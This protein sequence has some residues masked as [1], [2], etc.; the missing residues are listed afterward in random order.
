MLKQRLLFTVVLVVA[1][2]TFFAFDWYRQQ[3]ASIFYSNALRDARTSENVSVENREY[4]VVNGIVTPDDKNSPNA[5]KL[6]Y[7]KTMARRSPFFALPEI[8]LDDFEYAV[9][10]LE[11]TQEKLANLQKTRREKIL[12]GS[13]LYPTQFLKALS[14]TERARRQFLDSGSESDMWSYQAKEKKTL[15][16]YRQSLKRFRD[17]FDA[18]IPVGSRRYAMADVITDR[19]SILDSI[20]KLLGKAD[21]ISSLINDRLQCLKGNSTTCKNTDLRLPILKLEDSGAISNTSLDLSEDVRRILYAA[22]GNHKML[23]GPLVALSESS[24]LPGYVGG[25][26]FIFQTGDPKDG[27]DHFNLPRFVGDIRF[28]KSGEQPDPFSRYFRANGVEFLISNPFVY[29]KCLQSRTDHSK[30]FATRAI[31]EFASQSPIS[32]YMK[33]PDGNQLRVLEQLLFPTNKVIR[34]SD[35]VRYLSIAGTLSTAGKLPKD[36]S[37]KIASL[38]LAA[39]TPTNGFAEEIRRISVF[40]NLNMKLTSIGLNLDFSATRLFLTQ[41]AFFPLFLANNILNKDEISV[42]FQSNT[43]PA[44]KQPYIFYSSLPKTQM[45]RNE[46]IHDIGFYAQLH[47]HM[48]GI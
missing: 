17:A 32:E 12:V 21:K 20:D 22:T 8:N 6:A 2:G 43:I 47:P 5:L 27:T 1:V 46:L 35:A 4:S 13:S 16:V 33:G 44:E 36:I 40:E 26:L 48:Q 28:I 29:Y 34:E 37:N 10:E 41:S 45:L 3:S 39:K 18:V 24:C 25:S 11:K 31:S 30:L 15:F 42:L 14:E 38:I 19:Q 7:A 9:A 23:E